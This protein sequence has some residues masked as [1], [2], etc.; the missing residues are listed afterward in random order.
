MLRKLYFMIAGA[1]PRF[2]FAH[3][4]FN[5]TCFVGTVFTLLGFTLSFSLAL[6]L[7]VFGAS[8]VGIAY[9][10]LQ[11]Y[12]SR[13]RGMFLP[14]FIDA[15]VI[16]IQL[17][18]GVA[19]FYNAGSNGTIFY[20]L[21]VNYFIF[22]MIARPQQHVRLS[23]L[24]ISTVIGLLW[25]ELER[26][27]WVLGYDNDTQR[28]LDH[29]TVLAYSFIFTGIIVRLFRKDYDHEKAVIEKQ[30]QELQELY[31]RSSEKNQYIESLIRE[32]HHR[33]KNNLQVVSSMLALQSKRMQD[34][35]ARMALEDGRTRV[36]AM[37]L[38][39]QKLLLNNELAGVNMK[40]YLDNLAVSLAESYGFPPQRLHTTVELK[41]TTMDIDRAV[42]I[43]LIVNELMTNALKHAFRGIENPQLHVAL[44]Q[45]EEKLVL[46]VF[47]NGVG[48]AQIP[49]EKT[50]FGMKLVKPW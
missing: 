39:H 21:L 20:L 36:E 27:S 26:P 44:K 17:L 1:D 50:S 9:G 41:S 8:L 28:L 4:I 5:I 46:K 15:Y 24:F 33:I 35:N 43:G 37:A 38:I 19:F 6:P 47:D 49:D 30:R 22:M 11:Y 14:V 7:P 23:L 18:M 31:L 25:V 29:V 12:F 2:S 34:E 42:P 16:V 13:I 3:R 40:D 48:M 10:I 32:L 45:Y